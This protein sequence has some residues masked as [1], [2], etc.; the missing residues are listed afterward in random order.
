MLLKKKSALNQKQSKKCLSDDFFFRKIKKI[1]LT[2]YN[3]NKLI[4]SEIYIATR[5]KVQILVDLLRKVQDLT[6]SGP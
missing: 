5:I 6:T 1:H 3:H 4:Y 2:K